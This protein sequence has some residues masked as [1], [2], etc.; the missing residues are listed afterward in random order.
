MHII[1]T[2]KDTIMQTNAYTYAKEEKKPFLVDGVVEE[3][4]LTASATV[5]PSSRPSDDSSTI[6]KSSLLSAAFSSP[7]AT[8]NSSTM[9]MVLS[10]YGILKSSW[11]CKKA[12]S[13]SKSCWKLAT[14]ATLSSELFKAVTIALWIALNEL[15]SSNSA[16][17][18]LTSRSAIACVCSIKQIFIS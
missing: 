7:I 9:A 6:S 11:Y 5:N 15:L 8:K 4:T 1:Y 3:S 14:V 18:F 12:D 10:G 17:A 16:S 2:Y 13:K